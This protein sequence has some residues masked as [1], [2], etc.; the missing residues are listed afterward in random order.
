VSAAHTIAVLWLVFILTHLGV[1]SSRIRAYCVQRLGPR[2]YVAAYAVLSAM[3]LGAIGWAM[4]SLGNDEMPRAPLPTSVRYILAALSGLG[5]LLIAGGLASYARSPMA[6]LAR[7]A[8][9]PG[10][11]A[12][13]E[14]APPSAIARITRHPFFVGLALLMGAHAVFA[15]TLASTICALGFATL[16]VLGIVLQDRKLRRMH[17]EVYDRY[18]AQTSALPLAALGRAPALQARYV[19]R[20]AATALLG[21]VLLVLAHPLWQWRHGAGFAWLISVFGLLAVVRQFTIAHRESGARSE[22]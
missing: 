2:A 8:R 1:S 21:A 18:V 11:A 16:A 13:I 7:R 22:A 15:P 6:V 12:H 5:A 20:E 10:L 4:A 14:L 9:M 3:Q 17:G 19:V